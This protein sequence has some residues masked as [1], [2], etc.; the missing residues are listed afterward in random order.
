MSN[1]PLH[2]FFGIFIFINFALSAGVENDNV[3]RAAIDVGMAGPKLQVAEVNPKTNKLIKILH[4]ERFFVNFY[5]ALSEGINCHL[6][7]E[8]MADGL[9]AFREAVKIARLFNAEGIVAIATAS[10]RH[11]ANGEQFA[12]EIQNQTGIKVHIID[13]EL[14]GKLAF[15]AVLAKADVSPEDLVMWDIG[16]GSMQLVMQV[17]DGSYMMHCSQKGSGHFKDYI[18]ENIQ[19]KDSNKFKSPNPMSPEDIIQAEAYACDL[20]TRIENL[21]KE[22]IN[23]PT[24]MV[25]GAGSLFGLDISTRVG[26]KTPFLIED[27]KIVVDALKDK[28]DNDLGGDDFAFVKGSNSILVLGFMRGLKIKQM[29]IVNVNNADGAILYAP[30]WD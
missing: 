13:Q 4:T 12:F 19:H 1:K 15:Q 29:H 27:L 24:T 30:F 20:S 10:F 6:L 9:K 23:C 22:K 26:H 18:I 3:I 5:E 7:P 21:F 8:I 25:V 28:S 2:L 17:P 11:A 14:E 16:G